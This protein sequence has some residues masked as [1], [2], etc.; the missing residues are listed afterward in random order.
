MA[1]DESNKGVIDLQKEKDC[2]FVAETIVE[3]R[4]DFVPHSL[5]HS[6]VDLPAGEDKSGDSYHIVRSQHGEGSPALLSL[7]IEILHDYFL[8]IFHRALIGPKD[9][10]E[11]IEFDHFL[12][13]DNDDISLFD[14]KVK[15]FVQIPGG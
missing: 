2:A 10:I 9:N 4:F 13:A 5:A 6:V 8:P 14:G 3:P 11:T 1:V 15:Q 7:L 12:K